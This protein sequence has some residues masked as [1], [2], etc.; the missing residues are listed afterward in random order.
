MGK[1]PAVVEK[2]ERRGILNWTATW[3]RTGTIYTLGWGRGGGLGG[4][5]LLQNEIADAL[6]NNEWA[7]PLAECVP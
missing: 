2:P 6:S 1:R 4:G 5:M 7:F 3:L